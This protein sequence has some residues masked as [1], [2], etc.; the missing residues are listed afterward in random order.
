MAV[1]RKLGGQLGFGG[2]LLARQIEL[3][4]DIVRQGLT[5]L[6]PDGDAG[7]S[8]NHGVCS[9]CHISFMKNG[10]DCARC[11][12]RRIGSAH[13]PQLSSKIHASLLNFDFQAIILH[14]V[15]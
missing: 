14:P 6:P 8:F 1:D 3:V 13:A 5:N 2:Q 4:A 12:A 15:V 9:C 11:G 10:C 7:T